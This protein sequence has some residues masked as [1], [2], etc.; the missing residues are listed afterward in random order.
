MR[1]RLCSPGP[2]STVRALPPPHDVPPPS[3]SAPSG[4]SLQ[5]ESPPQVRRDC[6][7]IR[8][9][10][11]SAMGLP[12]TIYRSESSSEQSRRTPWALPPLLTLGPRA[13]AGVWASDA[14]HHSWQSTVSWPP[15]AS[16]KGTEG[17][18]SEQV[19]E[20]LGCHVVGCCW[21]HRQEATLSGSE[22]AQSDLRPEPS[23]QDQNAAHSQPCC[24]QKHL[25]GLVLTRD[26]CDIGLDMSSG[27]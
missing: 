19:P 25:R 13:K 1:P 5:G 20:G 23:A 9:H 16:G 8:S 6:Q 27:S 22:A 15:G 18:S 14:G 21:G 11:S 12:V 7:H 10:V 3:P 24:S 4:H 17:P 26:P 2:G